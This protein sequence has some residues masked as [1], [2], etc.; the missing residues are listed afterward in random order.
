MK[1]PSRLHFGIVDMRG[2]LG[3]THVSVGASIKKPGIILKASKASSLRVKGP[4][5]ERVKE[6]AE[7]ILEYSEVKD[8][9]EF[10]LI[11]DI[12]EHAGFGSGTQLALAVGTAISNLYDLDLEVEE[13]ASVLQRSRR[14]GVGTHA[15]KHG[16]F[17]VDGGHDANKPDAIPPLLFRAEVPDDW[18]FVVGLPDIATGFS[19]IKEIN[20]FRNLEPPSTDLIGE[21]SRIVLVQMMPAILEGDMEAFGDAMTGLDSRFGDYWL[22]VQGGRYSHPRIEEGVKFLMENGVYGAGQ[23]SWGPAFYGLV[24]GEGQA[25]D[26]KSKLCEFLNCEE[27]KGTSFY[28]RADNEGAII[29]CDK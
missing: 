9:A 5:S 26:L 13:I 16:G 28:T 25:M 14:S 12:P 1:T 19:G 24:K 20:A 17:I 2:D 22:K 18:L 27:R 10:N 21:V 4:R 6:F 11:S 8:G 23:S 29:S 3:R 15:F 7:K